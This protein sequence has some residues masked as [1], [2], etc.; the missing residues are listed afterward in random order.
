MDYDYIY[1][2]YDGLDWNTGSH[3]FGPPDLAR[4]ACPGCLIQ[5]DSPAPPFSSVPFTLHA[6]IQDTLELLRSTLP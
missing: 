2:I 6:Q 1:S 3:L 4:F 5:L